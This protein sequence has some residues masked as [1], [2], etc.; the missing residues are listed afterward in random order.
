MEEE[1]IILRATDNNVFICIMSCDFIQDDEH[2]HLPVHLF[3]EDKFDADTIGRFRTKLFL[4]NQIDV[5]I[6]IDVT[7]EFTHGIDYVKPVHCTVFLNLESV[8]VGLGLEDEDPFIYI[9]VGEVAFPT[10]DSESEEIISV[11]IFT[12]FRVDIAM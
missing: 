4:S 6:H 11:W 12:P 7:E 1:F 2:E 8:V 9:V 10:V 5:F 3:C